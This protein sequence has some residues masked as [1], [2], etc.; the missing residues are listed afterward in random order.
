M[1][2]DYDLF[3][4]MLIYNSCIN[5]GDYLI[6]IFLGGAI[7]LRGVMFYIVIDLDHDG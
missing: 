1:D 5:F 2:D 4:Y 3:I 7:D 6:C